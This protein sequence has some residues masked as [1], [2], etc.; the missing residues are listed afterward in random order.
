MPSRGTGKRKIL[1]TPSSL[2]SSRVER[3]LPD[4]SLWERIRKSRI[5]TDGSAGICFT[6]GP[7]A[8]FG[9]A[10]G[11]AILLGVFEGKFVV[12]ARH[13]TALVTY[14][15]NQNRCRCLDGPNVRSTRTPTAPPRGCTSTISRHH[16]LDPH[17]PLCSPLPTHLLL[18][19]GTKRLLCT[20][21]SR[22]LR[23]LPYH[24]LLCQREGIFFLFTTSCAGRSAKL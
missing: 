12:Q 9:G 6:A 8:A 17:A 13:N 18:P 23:N 10:V 16:C 14:F 11:C 15:D 5:G 3:W 19:L 24:T 21:T 1:G 4:V 20:S 2:V 22:P 7:K